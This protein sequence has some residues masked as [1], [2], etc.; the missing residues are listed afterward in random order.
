MVDNN[1]EIDNISVSIESSSKD[2]RM[3]MGKVKIIK[4]R[5]NQNMK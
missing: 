5:L 3:W 1:N 4:T 2:M